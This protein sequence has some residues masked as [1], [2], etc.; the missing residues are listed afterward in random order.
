MCVFLV[1][2]LPF[3]IF[4]SFFP[5]FVIFFNLI[6]CGGLN[7]NALHRLIGDGLLK[8]P[9]WKCGFFG[10]TVSQR[11]DL[12]F[13]EAQTMPSVTL[14]LLPADLELELPAFYLVPCL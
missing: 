9:Y 12:E 1:F 4:L 3:F 14:Y 5:S 13:S 6:V 10:G 2:F 11:V 8:D 7:E